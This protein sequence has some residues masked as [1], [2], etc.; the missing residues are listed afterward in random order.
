[1]KKGYF[2][3]LANTLTNQKYVRSYFPVDM[4]NPGQMYIKER[5]TFLAWHKGK[6]E[7]GA[8]FDF[9][10]EMEE[11]CRS[12]VDILRRECACFRRELIKS[13]EKDSYA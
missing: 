5:E 10:R 9:R 11:Y 12:D 13:M 6:I 4:Y 3:H 1:M 2:P 8:I 7:S